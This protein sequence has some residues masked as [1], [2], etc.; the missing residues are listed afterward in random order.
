[1]ALKLVT[2]PAAEPITLT[3]AKAHLRVDIPDDDTLINSLIVSARQYAEMVTRRALITQTWRLLLDEFPTENTIYIPLPPLSAVSSVTYYDLNNTQQTM[4]SADYIVDTDSQPGRIVL[5]DGKNWPAIYNRPN[6][7][8]IQFDAGYGTAANVPQ[9]IKQAMLL[10]IGHWY[11]NRE[12]VAAG[13]L[14]PLPFAVDALL[15]PYRVWRFG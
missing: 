7:V 13:G 11:E 3:E 14:S 4:P 1:M 8:S 6:A 9:P 10:M 2:P 5:A 15:A 12:A